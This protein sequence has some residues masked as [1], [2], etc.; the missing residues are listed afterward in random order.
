MEV[1]GEREG[2]GGGRKEGELGHH[3]INKCTFRTTKV[4]GA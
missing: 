1:G 3:V 4:H 2:R